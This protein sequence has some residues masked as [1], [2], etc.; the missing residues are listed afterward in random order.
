MLMQYGGERFN[1]QESG[2]LKDGLIFF[3]IQKC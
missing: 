2:F 1:F 3:Y